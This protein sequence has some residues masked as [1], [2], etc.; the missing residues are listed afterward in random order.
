MAS[1]KELQPLK[2]LYTMREACIALSVSMMTLRKLLD[3]GELD[4]YL[5]GTRRYVTVD[6]V[7]AFNT[8][9][10]AASRDPETGELR[11]STQLD[12]RRPSDRGKR[13][14]QVE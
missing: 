13:K 1:N 14:P 4:S 8:R 12:G 6:S 3:A 7:N 2:R 10:V 5:I 11:K 9:R